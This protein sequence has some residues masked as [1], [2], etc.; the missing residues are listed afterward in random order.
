[1]APVDQFMPLSLFSC[2]NSYPAPTCAIAMIAA[3][4]LPACLLAFLQLS[5]F[6]LKFAHKPARGGN[7]EFRKFQTEDFLLGY[8]DSSED[9]LT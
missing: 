4:T 9:D 6:L 5:S 2:G 1:M 7:G 3:T 8:A